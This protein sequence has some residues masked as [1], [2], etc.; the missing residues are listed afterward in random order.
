MPH[1]ALG[2]TLAT[3]LGLAGSGLGVASALARLP[4]AGSAGKRRVKD[5]VNRVFGRAE[6]LGLAEP[7][8]VLDEECR[9]YPELRLFEE[10]YPLIRAEC[11][12]LLERRAPL[13]P[14]RDLGG[15]YTADGIHTARWSVLMLKA[16]S[17]V[18]PNCLLCPGTAAAL[19][20][21]PFVY[22][23]FFS[24]L[25]PGQ[26]IAPHFGYY[27]GF[28][29]YHLG[30]CIPGDNADRSCWLR[31]QGDP[32]AN[33]RRDKSAIGG[34]RRYYW[35]EGRGVVFDDTLLHDAANESGHTRVVLWLDVLRKLPAPLAAF[36]RACLEIARRDRS[37]REFQK[38]VLA[39]DAAA[40]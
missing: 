34:G 22:T 4:G 9:G 25:E 7:L 6:A 10:R 18:E 12:Q 5:A 16:G 2:A 15:D 23:A 35:R 21:A 28:V 3:T 1:W 31:V 29:R 14:M 39:A 24:V 38:G 33:A 20:E 37:V 27:K 11:D 19:R 40:H 30:V 36:N 26:Y 13:T 32:E 8:P 17:F